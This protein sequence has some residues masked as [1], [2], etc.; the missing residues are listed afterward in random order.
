MSLGS[1]KL[2]KILGEDVREKDYTYLDIHSF[3]RHLPYRLL[4]MFRVDHVAVDRISEHSAP[5]FPLPLST[6]PFS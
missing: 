5:I 6:I 3:I 4:V 1:D 2:A